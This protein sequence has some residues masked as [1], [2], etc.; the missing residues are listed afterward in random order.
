MKTMA[1]GGSEASTAPMK[2]RSEATCRVTASISGADTK[3]G[4]WSARLK[5]VRPSA[6]RTPRP[7]RE[8]REA[9]ESRPT[10]NSSTSVRIQIEYRLEALRKTK[11]RRPSAVF[12]PPTTEYRRIQP[13][14]RRVE[15][16]K[17][18]SPSKTARRARRESQARE[19]APARPR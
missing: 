12:R 4:T 6:A 3:R 15:D 13:T 10:R 14:A 19:K 16:G 18:D 5:A 17:E 9:R 11:P 8:A 7:R 1:P 2:L